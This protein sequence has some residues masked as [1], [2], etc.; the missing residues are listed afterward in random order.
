[1]QEIPVSVDEWRAIVHGPTHNV[2]VRGQVYAG[3][4]PDEVLYDGLPILGGNVTVDALAPVRRTL[5]LTLVDDDGRFVDAARRITPGGPGD[6]FSPYGSMIRIQ[7]GVEVP[8]YPGPF[9]ESFYWL[10]EGWFRISTSDADGDGAVKITGSDLARTVSRAA[11]LV[12]IVYPPGTL[13]TAAIRNVV[14]GGLPPAVARRVCYDL[15]TIVDSEETT[16][17]I[18]LDAKADRWA[19]ATRMAKAIGYRVYFAENSGLQLIPAPDP[20]KQPPVARYVE[21]ETA[22]L[23]AAQSLTD[24]PGYNGVVLDA[25]A[26]TLPAPL[27]SIVWDENPDSP[28][29]HLGPYGEVPYFMT[30]AYV[31]SQVQADAA[32]RA[33][34]LR[35]IA[36]TERIQVSIVPDPAAQVED[37][38]EVRRSRSGIDNLYRTDRL[39][40]PLGEGDAMPLTCRPRTS[41]VEPAAA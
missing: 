2:A 32:A 35:W 12:P 31:A 19:E 28:T 13:Y 24:D 30:S 38:S 3:D 37:I 8:G 34:L 15:A 9:G 22:L 10:E 23:A 25:E 1:M 17:L 4:D 11:P 29:Y 6:I 33:E 20:A 7:Y 5:D 26:T 16:P 39:V 14:A 41:V 21:N 36:G 27:R 40:L 18:V